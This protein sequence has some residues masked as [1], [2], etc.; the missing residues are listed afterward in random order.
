MVV[1]IS[2]ETQTV[3]DTV[4]IGGFDWRD[5]LIGLGVHRCPVDPDDYGV[6]FGR[7]TMRQAKRAD[8]TGTG[9]MLRASA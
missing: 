2:T 9:T 7:H 4:K 1:K 3:R 5:E 6:F 8:A